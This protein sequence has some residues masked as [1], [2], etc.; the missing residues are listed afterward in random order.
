MMAQLKTKKNA[1]F[2]LREKGA[3]AV[4]RLAALYPDAVC[5][6]DYAGDP[7][8]LLVMARLSAQCTDERVNIVCGPMFEAIPDAETMAQTEL[9]V[10]EE[11]VKPCGLYRMKAKSIKEASEILVREYGGRVPDTMDEL[12][13]LPGVGRKIANLLLGDI[14]GKGGIVADTHCM[15]I[16]GR[17]GFYPED[18]RDPVKTER[19]LT[20]IIEPAAQSDFCHRLV[21]F[22][23]EYCTA[24]SPVCEKGETC[25]LAEICAHSGKK[26]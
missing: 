13:A 20:P 9:S 18:L 2:A 21:H 15:R 14:F 16:C 17:L 11:F 25:P 4:S 3:E 24:R 5:S 10:I 19:I 7:W 8:K 23:R 1:A 22:G 12:L 6:L 26:A